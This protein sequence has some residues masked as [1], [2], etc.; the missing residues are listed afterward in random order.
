MG[1]RPSRGRTQLAQL[2][3]G[4]PSTGQKPRDWLPPPL[5]VPDRFDGIKIRAHNYS[6]STHL[7]IMHFQSAPQS[8]GTLTIWNFP[9]LRSA[10]RSGQLGRSGS[11]SLTSQLVLHGQW[12]ARVPR[13]SFRPLPPPDDTPRGATR[14]PTHNFSRCTRNLLAPPAHFCA[15]ARRWEP[16]SHPPGCLRKGAEPL[17]TERNAD[18]LCPPTHVNVRRED[19]GRAKSCDATYS[20]GRAAP[21]PWSRQP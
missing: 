8:T 20:L 13:A 2:A 19:G 3:Q 4:T 1:G 12:Q 14:I 7:L 11:V 10:E 6:I 17:F 9:L 16:V 21:R 15:R 18:P 5:L